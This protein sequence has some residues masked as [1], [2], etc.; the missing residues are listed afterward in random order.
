MREY[1]DLEPS[2]TP[3]MLAAAL[4]SWHPDEMNFDLV[5]RAIHH[6]SKNKREGLKTLRAWAAQW[7]SAPTG[8]ELEALWRNVREP[9][10]PWF[11]LI[12][13][14]PLLDSEMPRLPIELETGD[15]GS[16]MEQ[17]AVLIANT[18][19]LTGIMVFAGRL[20]LLYRRKRP[21]FKGGTVESLEVVPLTR[22]ALASILDK[23][24]SFTRR[25]KG[26][27]GSTREIV[28]DCPRGLV[29]ELLD[30]PD[31]WLRFRIPHVDCIAETPIF[32]NCELIARRGFCS[33]AN[34][35]VNAP[36]GIAIPED[37]DRQSA[38]ES[39]CRI[40][41]WLA[42]FPF[43]TPTDESVAISFLLTA[44]LRASLQPI[45]GF[46]LD[47]PNFGAGASTLASLVHIVMTGR[48]PA[49]LSAD[50]GPEELSKQIDAAQMA[51]VSAIFI[52]NFA[53]GENLK[54]ESLAQSL[55]ESTRRPRRLGESENV[56]VSCNQLICI[57]GKNIGVARDLVRR[58]LVCR[59]NP[60]GQKPQDRKFKRP[61][62]LNEIASPK[63]RAA[64]LTD[65][66]T[67]AAA[68]CRSESEPIGAVLLGFEDW[69][70][71]CANSL[72]WLGMPDPVTSNERLERDDPETHDFNDVGTLWINAYSTTPVDVQQLLEIGLD[73][74]APAAKLAT[75]LREAAGVI[76]RTE[77]PARVVGAY[78][79]KFRDN[80]LA[81]GHRLLSVGTR[82]RR[83]LWAFK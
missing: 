44:A 28:T 32:A 63:A 41:E 76:A 66:Y 70:H 23:W 3:E 4:K 37:V 62:L 78:L 42:E 39:L 65:L 30:R 69:S 43:E 24:A 9:V 11:W 31:L 26:K 19:H 60:K 14:A 13:A 77:N 67:V 18:S 38:V 55:S 15:G 2:P 48:R 46:L 17:L 22:G 35:F 40:R 6:A 75:K 68:Y 25:S 21:G 64:L 27:N 82:D 51:G 50:R 73:Y 29:G 10:N 52:D 56:E 34:A 1:A 7:D 20:V 79:K 12:Y 54:S 8:S 72:V 71:L 58:V 36:A 61:N 53:E 81:S 80:E 5:M 59:L 49:V 16:S 47:K 83:Q 45:P 57:N 74:E 33:S